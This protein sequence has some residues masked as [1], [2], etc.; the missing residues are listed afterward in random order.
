VA[1]AAVTDERATVGLIVDG[2][3]CHPA[4]VRLAI[5]AKGV[6]RSFLVSGEL[7]ACSALA[8]S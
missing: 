3:H 5:R 6:E 8:R 7:S 4:S 1:G 2:I